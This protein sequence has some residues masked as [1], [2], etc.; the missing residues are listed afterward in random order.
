MEELDALWFLEEL[1][2]HWMVWKSGGARGIWRTGAGGSWKR[3]R[4]NRKIT[5]Q[6]S[7]CQY[8]CE[9]RVRHGPMGRDSQHPGDGNGSLLKT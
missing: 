7:V 9:S 1:E 3:V 2:V 4:L 5:F 6:E 8:V